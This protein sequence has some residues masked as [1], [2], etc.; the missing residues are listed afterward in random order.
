[1]TGKENRV[2]IIKYTGIIIVFITLSLFLADVS[3]SA[4]EVLPVVDT[5]S[6]DTALSLNEISAGQPVRRTGGIPMPWDNDVRMT[7]EDISFSE[8]K[9]RAHGEDATVMDTDYTPR[10]SL[11]S[12]FPGNTN[13]ET[14]SII[15]DKY[16][17]VKDQANFGTCWDFSTIAPVEFRE[18]NK[19]SADKSIDLSELYLGLGIYKIREN[20]IVGN[21]DAISEII[22]ILP[23]G[24]KASDAFLLNVGGNHWIT[25]QYLS[26]GFGFISEEDLPYA[27]SDEDIDDY[28]RDP[29]FDD[30][31]NLNIDL[32]ALADKE[33]YDLTDL[34]QVNIHD[35]N[36]M[37]IVKEAVMQNGAVGIG[38]NPGTS[39]VELFT[40]CYKTE[41]HAFYCEREGNADHLVTV[42]GWNDNFSREN[43]VNDPGGDGAW[44]VRNSWS[45]P[46]SD[47]YNF[48]KYFWLS[49]Y[50]KGLRDG[51]YIF[52]VTKD[53]NRYDNNY[54]YDTQIHYYDCIS[55]DISVANVYKVQKDSNEYLNEVTL[56][57]LEPTDYEIEIY[58]NLKDRSSPVSGIKV[59]KSTTKGEFALPG[60]YTV[61]LAAPALLEKD[62]YFSVV[63]RTGSCSVCFESNLD[64]PKVKVK[65]GI[66]KGQ[67]Y[68]LDET[69]WLD[70]AD[71]D[72][73]AEGS[74][75]GNF[76]ISA[77]T[78]FTDDADIEV[79]V[80]DTSGKEVT[81]IYNTKYNTYKTSDGKD[82]LVLST[83][84]GESVP[85]PKYQFTGKKMYPAKKSFVVYKGTLYKYKT[86]YSIKYKKNKNRGSAVAT[87]KW[88]KTSAP[89][90]AGEKKAVMTFNIVPRTVT[91]SMVSYSLKKNK[92]KKLRVKADGITMKPKKRDYSY[93]VL[94]SGKCRITFMNDYSGVTGDG[95]R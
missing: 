45:I 51:A 70:L 87:V 91:D 49:Y 38:F 44:L 53:V 36:G 2:K 12:R 57:F 69:E 93:T 73:W 86:D 72:E 63:V 62:T 47:F 75:R 59:E 4:D 21:E 11:P 20:P 50:D 9:R 31:N 14:K 84:T 22:P 94:G 24:E 60:I 76:C 25:G 35:E 95:S 67:S 90:K 55:D 40:R 46:G 42:V 8:I 6:G 83:E 79:K 85:A 15:M 16:P 3:V 27:E 77:H 80:K 18:I 58:R 66:K 54:Y 34:Y 92:L 17:A 61:P 43:F 5:L 89:Y 78:V 48:S 64:W 26:K 7:D 39:S 32:D 13:D 10:A 1:M 82:V 23:D 81:L 71:F 28:T 56:E 29:R 41:T 88:K 74:G 65:C 52:E 37:K 30:E 33:I 19:G 68:I